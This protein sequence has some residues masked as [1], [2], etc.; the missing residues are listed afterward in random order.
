MAVVRRGGVGRGYELM[1]WA[2]HASQTVL[3]VLEFGV[4]VV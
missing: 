4:A 1:A 3:W 2:I